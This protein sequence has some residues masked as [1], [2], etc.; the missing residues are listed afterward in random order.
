MG[1][2]VY[3]MNERTHHLHHLNEDDK[4]RA[5]RSFRWNAPQ[6]GW[7]GC[8][9]NIFCWNNEVLFQ[10]SASKGLMVRPGV[11]IVNKSVH[12]EVMTAITFRIYPRYQQRWADIAP[13]DGHQ[14]QTGDVNGNNIRGKELNAQTSLLLKTVS[15]LNR[16]ELSMLLY[17]TSTDWQIC[18]ARY[19]QNI[20]YLS[21]CRAYKR[22][23]E[24]DTL[25][26]TGE[27]CWTR[28]VLYGVD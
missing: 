9:V 28:Q 22:W 8:L 13:T 4:S 1:S 21:C 12:S 3:W 14:W 5:D 17:H 25:K 19:A 7:R 20:S 10:R 16:R 15:G 24:V 26:S 6:T 23:R 27:E 2:P 18:T 11:I